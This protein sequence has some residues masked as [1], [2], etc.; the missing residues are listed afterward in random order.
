[1]SLLGEIRPAKEQDLAAM[2]AWRNAPAVRA[3]M[4][5]Q[6]E[7]TCAEHQAWWK[8]VHSS[9]DQQHFIY[10]KS[11]EAV[12]VISFSLIDH[13]HKSCSWA[14]YA[15]PDAP[16]GTGALMEF[17]ALEYVF[18]TLKLNK[19]YCEVLA[20]NAPTIRLH[21]RFGFQVEGIFRDQYLL[22]DAFVDI[23]RLGLL[24]DEWA[25]KRDEMHHKL[26]VKLRRK[27]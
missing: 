24:Q 26:T 10:E 3:N 2:R 15:A 27:L 12:G 6:H 13:L 11:D 23:Y 14:Y 17:L 22:D 5:T 4:Y 20:Y 25:E 7:I 8:R 19:I 18:N 1:M 16:I 9:A 21:Q